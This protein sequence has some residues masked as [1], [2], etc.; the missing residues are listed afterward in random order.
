SRLHLAPPTNG[1]VRWVSGHQLVYDHPTLRT[2]ATYE[3]ML[4]PGYRDPAGNTYTLRHHWSFIT[5]GPPGLSGSNPTNGEGGVDPS[6]YLSLDFSRVMEP[7]TLRSA[8]S[9]SPSAAF[10][11]RLDS[12]DSRRAIIAPY[13]LLGANT[14]Y[15]LLINTR[16]EGPPGL[17]GPNPTNGEGGVDP[18][19]YLSLDFSRV[20]EPSTLRS[21][22]S[23]SPSAA[24]DVRLDS[25]DSRRAIIA[26]YQLLG[27]NTEYQ[28]LINT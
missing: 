2:N 5:E 10:D 8:I 18:S 15:Q 12:T 7:S 14:E 19:A 17:S 16:S 20:M 13:Q 28:L 6:A 27:A 1:S 9:F 11:V 26:P 21:A 25:T 22:I 24:F 23:F 4:E 3:V